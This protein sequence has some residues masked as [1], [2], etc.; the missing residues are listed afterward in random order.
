MDIKKTTAKHKNKET[1]YFVKITAVQFLVCGFMVLLIFGVCRLSPD[2]GASVKAKYNEIM[3]TDISL[4]QVWGSVKEVAEYVMKPVDVEGTQDVISAETE[5]TKSVAEEITPSKQE[6]KTTTASEEK[7]KQTEIAA[8]MSI[9]DDGKEISAPVHGRI[10]SYFGGRTDPI[11]GENDTHNAID[12]AVDEGT[13]VSAA[14]DGVVTETG[15]DSIRGNYIWLVHKNGNET[16]YC[17]CSQILVN[18]GTVIRAGETIAFS[19]NTGYSTGPHLHFA[20][21][22]NG[23]YV[24]PLEYLTEKDGKI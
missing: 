10:T 7:S 13:S 11:S 14:W 20:V 6:E 3:L 4:A 5:T 1:D 9:F 18:E 15:N 12:I 2:G 24:D 23:E 22:E 21:K 17:H 8:V 19:G 16:F